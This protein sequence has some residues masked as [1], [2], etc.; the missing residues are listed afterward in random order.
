MPI[1]F[2]PHRS[3]FIL[4]GFIVRL[5]DAGCFFRADINQ[6]E[7]R[8]GMF[9][10]LRLGT[11]IIAG[12]L[13][14]TAIAGVMGIVGYAGMNQIMAQTDEIMG[15]RFPSVQSL[16]IMSEAQ[17]AVLAGERRQKG[18]HHDFT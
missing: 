1:Q 10:N 7:R 3:N 8:N 18:E 15:N 17:N 6:E 5:N 11:K 13:A 14:V 2:L 12:F 16:L 4:K 9:K